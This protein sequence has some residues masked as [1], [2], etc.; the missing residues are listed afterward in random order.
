MAYFHW[1]GRGAAFAVVALTACAQL[2]PQACV[3][4]RD[5]YG[6][7]ARSR[8]VIVDFRKSVPCPGTGK[9]SGPCH[10]YVVD[11]VQPLCACGLDGPPNLLWSTLEDAKIKDREERALCRRLGT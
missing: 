11:H 6:K 2:P 8:Q 7:I 3:P 9:T 10:G 1:I 4:K 5:E